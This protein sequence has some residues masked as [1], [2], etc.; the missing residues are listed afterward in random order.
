MLTTR[1]MRIDVEH[2]AE[3]SENVGAKKIKFLV[4]IY[5]VHMLNSKQLIIHYYNMKKRAFFLSLFAAALWFSSCTP[6]DELPLSEQ[7]IGVWKDTTTYTVVRV[8]SNGTVISTTKYDDAIYTFF[9]DGTYTTDNERPFLGITQDGK[10]ELGATN[11]EIVFKPNPTV[12]DSF[13]PSNKTY[14]WKIESIT[15]QSMLVRYRY[16]DDLASV[17]GG[18]PID[19]SYSRY[20]ERQQ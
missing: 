14:T 2:R 12:I 8:D 5:F 15:D 17:I 1:F 10:W 19:H 9:N 16:T 20:F 4:P 6:N 11:D 18:I 7:I 13:L 3:K